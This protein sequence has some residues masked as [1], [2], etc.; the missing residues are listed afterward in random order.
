MKEQLLI[1]WSDI[2]KEHPELAGKDPAMGMNWDI[3][4]EMIFAYVTFLALF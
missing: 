3:G 4:Q 1:S 2:V